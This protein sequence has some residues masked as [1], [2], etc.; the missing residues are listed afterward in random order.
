[1]RKCLYGWINGSY[2]FRT[3]WSA[4]Q[5][6]SLSSMLEDCN[7]R[8][9]RE[10]HR[11]IRNIKSVKFWKGTEY[12]TFLL[13]LGPVVLKDLLCIEAYHN[14]LT[15]F[16]A[17]TIVSCKSYLK[18]IQIADCLFKDYIGQFISIY[19]IDAISSNVHNVAHVINDVKKFG[20]LSEISTYPFENYLGQ[21]KSLVRTGNRPLSQIAKRV[22]EFSVFNT[23]SNTEVETKKCSPFVRNEKCGEQHQLQKCHRIFDTVC[24]SKDFI[25][26]NNFKD[27]WFLTKRNNIVSMINATYFEGNIFI[28]G[29]EIKTK[30]DFFEFPIKSS[31][32][33]IY[34]SNGKTIRPKLYSL[35]DI[36]CK[37][38]SLK[39]NNEFVFL[40]LIHTLD[41]QL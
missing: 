14:F 8:K 23:I 4:S 22:S 2:N 21:L 13:Y 16:S 7:S 20:N 27:G 10:I 1:M 9:P 32:L 18:Y 36:K 19:G 38:F 35:N 30:W 15:L 17:V 33:N 29:S 41:I 3:K 26:C 28:Y 5:I 31:Y 6:A 12:R 39:Y 37:L 34:K 25:L 24:I 11:S 40:P